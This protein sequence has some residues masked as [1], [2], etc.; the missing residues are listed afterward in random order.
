MSGLPTRETL[1]VTVDGHI[2]GLSLAGSRIAVGWSGPGHAELTVEEARALGWLLRGY[3]R[4]AE[5]S[6]EPEGRQDRHL[7]EQP[8]LGWCGSGTG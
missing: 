6:D 1:T 8:M 2:I 5:Q 3:A 4:L 7:I